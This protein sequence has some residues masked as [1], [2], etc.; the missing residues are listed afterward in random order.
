MQ[1]FGKFPKKSESPHYTG[2]YEF[3]PFYLN[4]LKRIVL[5]D[6]EP[7]PLTP[8]CFDILLAL[9]EHAGEVLVKEELMESV[10]PDTVVEEG[11]LNRN[12]STLRKVLGESPNDHRYIVTVPGR[13]YRFV[14]EVREA[15]ERLPTITRHESRGTGVSESL[16]FPHEPFARKATVPPLSVAAPSIVHSPVERHFFGVRMSALWLTVGGTVCAVVLAI[17]VRFG[18]RTKPVL[19]ATDQVLI[20]D[21]SN[22]T[23][24]PVFDDTLKQAVSVQL[25]QS[26][27]LN[28][29]SDARIRATLQLMTLPPDAKLTPNLARE[30]C[31]RTESK[32]YIA[33]SIASLGNQYVVGLI[34]VDCQT[35]DSLAQEQAV[36]D[37]KEHVL[38]ALDSAATKLRSK[39]GESLNTVRRY[40][41]PLQQATTSSLEA[42]KA[43]S[44]GDIARDR[45]GDAAAIPFFQHAVEI[46]P[47]FALAYDA[48]G[49][50]FSNLDEPGLAAQNI[51]RAYEMRERASER[52]KF[53]I[54]ANYSQIVT[55]ELEKSNQICEL[56]AQ[57]YPRDVYPH[58][59]LGVN[60]E[61]QGQ[62]EKAIAETREAVRLN[63]DGVVLR[64]NLMEDYAALNRL[65]EAKLAF[66]QALERKLDHPYLH[67]DMYA[68]A[69][70]QGDTP[71]MDRQSAW[72]IGVPGGED[73]LLSIA[74]DTQA[75]AGKLAKAREYSRR[76][77]D[78]AKR[79]NQKETSAGWL[80]NEALREAEFGN[81]MLARQQTVEALSLASTRDVQLLAAL[82]LA[83]AG[84]SSQAQT[85]ADDLAKLF[86]LNTVING[87]WLPTIRAAI[88][89]NHGAPA[90]A[91]DILATAAPNDSAYPN[92][93]VEVGRFLYPIFVRGQAYLLMGRA[94]EAIGE[95]QKML[96]FPALIV[97]CP[98]GPLAHL[99]LARAYT[100]QGDA[101]KARTAYDE[102]FALWK[103]ADANIPVLK[104]A[105]LEYAKLK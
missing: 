42:L 74:S 81:F 79:N 80:M 65:D 60:Y 50:T 95:F 5:R 93:Q 29:L 94:N 85:M 99:G 2:L 55:G 43:F 15:P 87:Y 91:L 3:G 68:I 72:S 51:T 105:K 63:P 102:F 57:T 98:L 54:T 37:D 84:S 69:F 71:E 47:Q 38:K 6:G 88:E 27:Y 19:S 21:F 8:K 86:P 7:L 9:V 64:S 61:F 62:Y 73:L 28:I 90:K 33:G 104:Q 14:A 24:D 17:L 12:I 25:T 44:M 48:L 82:T 4:S 56:W 89:L 101:T 78:V 45:K 36:A 34:S 70:L 103:D 22:T 13:G 76:A 40:D 100:L 16:E 30:I 20:A 23:G 26:P 92:P 11:N 97:N 35:G 41:V 96:N 10:W 32:A 58:N 52:E 59:L 1:G 18:F 53:Q 77:V 83:R 66:G 49:I 31:Q 75:F 46:D 67:A 39:L